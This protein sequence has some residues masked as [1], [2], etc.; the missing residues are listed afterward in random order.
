[1]ALC[2]GAAWLFPGTAVWAQS[3]PE[4]VT[5]DRPQLRTADA[6]PSRAPDGGIEEVVVTARKLSENLQSVP[7]SIAVLSGADLTNQ[8]VKS[9]ADIQGQIPN[10]VLQQG[11]I[12]PQSLTFAI[13]GQKQND[14]PL[15]VDPSVGLYIDGLYDP[16]TLGLSGAMLDIDRVE[17]LR[18][19]QGT[20]YGRNT[21]GGAM[22]VYTKDPTNQFG[23]MFDVTGGNFG[24]WNLVGVLNLPISDTVSFRGVIQRGKHD[25]YGHDELGHQLDDEDSLY[26]R[27]KLRVLLGDS[28]EAILSFGDQQNDT[29]GAIEPIAGLS[30]AD[31]VAG[32][33][34]G[35]ISTLETIAETKGLAGLAPGNVVANIGPAVALLNSYVGRSFYNT[36]GTQATWSDF[37]GRWAGLS[38]TASLPHDLTLKSITGFQFLHRDNALDQDETPLNIL[39]S[40]SI[41]RDKYYSQEFQLLGGNSALNW[42]TGLY[43]STERGTEYAQI[44]ALPLL[45]PLNPAHDIAAMVNSSEAVYAQANWQFRPRWRLTVGGR[46]SF[47]QRQV[48]AEN[49]NLSGCTVPA[50]GVTLTPPGASECP[51]RFSIDFSEPSFLVSLDYQVTDDLLTYAKVARGYRA[52]GYNFRGANTIES[53][54]PFN[55]EIVVEYEA[56]LKSESF[57]RTLRFNLAV[58][59]D[60]YS[61]IQRSVDVE[62]QAGPESAVLNAA[63]AKINGF[64]AEA[65]WRAISQLE[66]SLDAGLTDA[67]Y[68]TFIDPVYGDRSG[69]PFGVPKWTA[70]T[71]AHYVVPLPSSQLAFQ[72]DYHWQSTNVLAPEVLP[73]VAYEVTQKAYGLLDARITLQLTASNLDLALYG[74]N[75]TGK[76]YY[77]A[78][79][80]LDR[81][82]GYNVVVPGAPRTFGLE[83]TKRFGAM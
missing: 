80:A 67:K 66:L 6:S 24:A 82:L 47:D 43:G 39:W 78:A 60:N 65:T 48:D 72:A 30:P 83:L 1:M 50:P 19:P 7:V 75:L 46:Y 73:A 49:D 35:G 55:P 16:R 12:D 81:A 14:I 54:S 28:V 38:I 31:P 79:N 11:V 2:C 21:T 15:N 64:E 77:A 52:G 3:A 9:L 37:H 26:A 44:I 57:D 33:P 13:R 69:E 68:D 10:L 34:P 51:R 74:R 22:T 45:N 59:H 62:T 8:S 56:G 71:S 29:G 36:S 32:L 18:G 53:F 58:Y 40:R 42:V 17:V 20:L 41:T 25:G 76:E 27:G 70:G 4:G 63:K 23:A 61:N 5:N